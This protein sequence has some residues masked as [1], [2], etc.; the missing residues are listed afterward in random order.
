MTVRE[1][2]IFVE[3]PK[4]NMIREEK[5]KHIGYKLRSTPYCF[6]NIIC[7]ERVEI[8]ASGWWIHYRT[9]SPE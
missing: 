2:N 6:E 1:D 8:G 5:N 7:I 9:A 3:D 4:P